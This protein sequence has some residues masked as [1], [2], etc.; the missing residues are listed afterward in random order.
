MGDVNNISPDPRVEKERFQRH[1]PYPN[2]LVTIAEFEDTV[3]V[4]KSMQKPKKIKIKGSD[5]REYYFLCKSRV[6]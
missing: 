4:M 1:S 3:E 2:S 5:G 6:C